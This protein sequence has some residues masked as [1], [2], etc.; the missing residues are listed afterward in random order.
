MS[1]FYLS[2]LTT[3]SGGWGL[4]P[5]PR[6]FFSCVHHLAGAKA[7]DLDPRTLLTET[8]KLWGFPETAPRLCHCLCFQIYLKPPYPLG[9]S[10]KCV[11][12]EKNCF[13][14]LFDTRKVRDQRTTSSPSSLFP[15][16]GISI[17]SSLYAWLAILVLPVNSALNPVLYTLTTTAFKQQVIS[18][19]FIL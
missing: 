11:T 4:F 2:S 7:S 9:A 12:S 14:K 19:L 5:S 18:F 16:T 6:A 15:R 17:S 3:P 1:A 8:R 10:P 13:P